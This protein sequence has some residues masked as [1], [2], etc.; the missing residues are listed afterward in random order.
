MEYSEAIRRLRKKMLLTQQE[1]AKELG[2]AFVTINRWENGENEPSMKYKRKLLPL[3][4]R[5]CIVVEDN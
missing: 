2:V 3:F 5:Y 4:K 1:F